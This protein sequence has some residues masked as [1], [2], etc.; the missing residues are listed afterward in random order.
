MEGKERDRGGQGFCGTLETVYREVSHI[1]STIRASKL[2]TSRNGQRS[3]VSP[4]SFFPP[5]SV[6]SFYIFVLSL[7]LK[8]YNR[9]DLKLPC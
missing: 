2:L 9:V 5:P 7:S 8:Y 6:S 3:K 4:M 1:A